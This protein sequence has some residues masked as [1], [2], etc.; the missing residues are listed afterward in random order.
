MDFYGSNVKLF[1]DW[2][3]SGLVDGM[4]NVS[5]VQGCYFCYFYSHPKEL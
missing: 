3:G 4:T 5:S 1:H 2:G